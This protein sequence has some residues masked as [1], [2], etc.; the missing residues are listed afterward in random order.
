MIPQ[1]FRQRAEAMIIEVPLESGSVT[2]NRMG[3]REIPEW[4]LADSVAVEELVILDNPLLSRIQVPPHLRTLRVERCGLRYFPVELPDSLTSLDLSNNI[5]DD[6][7]GFAELPVG[8]RILNLR[9]NRLSILPKRF[10]LRLL[11]TLV[12]DSNELS[13]IPE[14]LPN[15]LEILS[16]CGNRLTEMP[17]RLPR[18]LKTLRMANNQITRMCLVTLS[19]C[20]DLTSLDMSQNRIERLDTGALPPKLEKLNLSCNSLCLDAPLVFPPCIQHLD[21]HT[22]KL[23]DVSHLKFPSY[24]LLTEI[25]VPRRAEEDGVPGFASHAEV[26]WRL[27]RRGV[28]PLDTSME[29]SSGRGVT[30]NLSDNQRLMHIAPH[31][32]PGNVADLRLDHCGLHDLPLD[33]ASYPLQYL[34]ASFNYL[35]QLDVSKLPSSLH[36]L[37]LSHNLI[38]TVSHEGQRLAPSRFDTL[39]L[40]YNSLSEL[41]PPLTIIPVKML[42]LNYN[43][44]TVFP[45]PFAEGLLALT[46]SGNLLRGLGGYR[47]PASLRRLDVTD[48]HIM[49]L[50]GPA[51]LGTSP[52]LYDLSLG[53]NPVRYVA[54]DIRLHL[55]RVLPEGQF[56]MV[57]TGSIYTDT[58]NVHRHDVQDSM[59]E[60][61]KALVADG[62]LA[63]APDIDAAVTGFVSMGVIHIRALSNM[64]SYAG[65][66]LN[67]Q[68]ISAEGLLASILPLGAKLAPCEI[69]LGADGSSINFDDVMRISWCIIRD[70][71]E[72]DTM[73]RNIGL[74]LGSGEV[75]PC[76]TGI[77]GALIGCLAGFEGTASR[78]AVRISPS[79]QLAAIIEATGR[80]IAAE[81]YTAERHRELARAEMLERGFSEEEAA[82]WLIHIEA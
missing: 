69:N 5:V 6:P 20:V 45:G 66:A 80:S 48:N 65:L 31:S 33:L 13:S 59:R 72:R 64:L 78:I 26:E 25:P 75:V 40:S 24:S 53:G 21:L 7:S 29:Q 17:S 55:E 52:M 58:Q 61:L 46:L 15:T 12:V 30:V 47:L 51:L 16:A 50:S 43:A 22:N 18:N 62:I 19:R 56:E 34:S 38:R 32:L 2:L 1:A 57:G 39:N 28:T 77:I 81:T 49:A 41:P 10:P 44:I 8:L 70:H 36:F 73:I 35:N 37:N 42:Q 11:T 3:L 4:L 67:E 27:P 63:R 68:A 79:E 54:P 82:S 23:S 76:M 9:D 71:P 14:I 60:S 74:E